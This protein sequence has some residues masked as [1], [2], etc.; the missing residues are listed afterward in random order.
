MAL[1]VFRKD[2]WKWV[3]A[4]SWLGLAA[5]GVESGSEP[6]LEPVSTARHA[7]STVAHRSSTTASVKAST[8]LTLALPP[9]TAVGDVLLA[10]VSNRESV[11]ATLTAPAGWTLLRSD[12]SA[13]LLKSWVFYKVVSSTEPASYTFTLSAAYNMSGSVSAFSGADPA[14]PIDTH[15][16]QKNGNATALDS[17]A[18]TTTVANGL[19]VWFG[20]QLWGGT[21]CPV[22]P[23]VPPADFTEVFDACLLSSATGFLFDMAWKELGAAG[24]Q[25][26]FNGT[27]PFPNTNTAQ[28]VVLRPANAPTCT[29]G[30][31]FA[32]TYSVVGSVSSPDI[33]EPS[34][35]AASRIN[36]G[37]LYVHNEDTTAIVAISTANA[38]TLGTYQVAGVTPQDWEDVA[39]G[40]CPTGSCIY[41]GDIGRSSASLPIPPNTFY[42]YRI[43]E[44]NIGA[45][46]TSGTLSAEQFPFV[47]PDG[48]KDAESIMVHPVTADIYIIT[49]NVTNGLSKVY[50]LPRPLPAPGVVSTLVFVSDLQLPTSS[51]TNFSR[52]TAAAIHPCGNRF[53]LRTYRTV[54][55]FRAAENAA[56]ETAFAAAPVTLTDTV[57]GQ[58]EAIEY[59]PDGAAYFT[60]SESPS[61]FRLKRVNRQ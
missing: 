56:F 37:A 22:S 60:M 35:L 29:V 15:S 20:T 13:A 39:S 7:L 49:K 18:V 27:S 6:R 4:V 14:N 21:A 33:V 2:V 24:L 61:P 12:Q 52:A 40:P 54:Y 17:P 53:I 11:T 9:G 55:E 44:P 34:G 46:Q 45:G 10:R 31:T 41:M 38:S 50:K 16:G 57:E 59:A 43:P 48:G 26:A 36:P 8:T 32:S 3:A 58:G 51:D 19:A 23:L 28:V 1:E 42:V 25:P 5:C 30:D 47:Y